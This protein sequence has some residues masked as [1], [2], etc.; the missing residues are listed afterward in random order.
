MRVLRIF[1]LS[2]RA[3]TRNKMRTALTMLGIIIGVGAVIAMVSIG[4]G[5]K[6]AVQ[7]RFE[8]MGTNNLSLRSGS[9]R[10][11]GGVQSGAGS[12]PLKLE[13]VDLIKQRCPSVQYITP[14]YQ[15][16][17]QVVFGNKN[18]NTSIQGVNEN[19]E[20]IGNWNLDYT[21]SGSRF[22][23][24]KEV[25]EGAR[26]CVLG[27]DT[28]AKIFPDDDPIGQILRIKTVVFEVIGVLR[29]KGQSG[30]FG[31]RDD[32]IL[33]PYTTVSTR[34]IGANAQLQEI[35]MAAYS[36][37]STDA[38]QREV[39]TL[40]REYNRVQPGQA[41]N[42]SVRNMADIAES[43][44]ESQN[45]F[46]ILLGSIASIS[47]LVGGIG[48]MNI[49]LVS[50]TERIREIGIRM[51]V[52]GQ[53]E[54]ILIQFLFEAIVLS[55]TGGLIGIGFG[56]AVSKLL[57]FI[58]MFATITTIVSPSSIFLAFGFSVAVGV[59]FGFYPARKASRLDPIE[60]LRY[61]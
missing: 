3:L 7:S 54:D 29:A 10:G 4:A 57:H 8:A 59:F 17:A 41:D 12:L 16:R 44:A 25:E 31:S 51:A 26:V 23:T 39:E 38:A 55:V 5:A 47:L 58:P 42:F 21:Y 35:Q 30:G 40:M 9:F 14:L 28:V 2:L 24:Q 34:I 32:L 37:S 36:A 27:A 33:A 52:G 61:E 43:A 22:F 60:A 6:A 49:M 46:T 15:T 20:I 48:I 45:I 56:F 13:L 11:P 50:V 18:W 19:Y 53:E 1:R